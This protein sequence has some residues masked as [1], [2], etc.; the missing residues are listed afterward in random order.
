MTPGGTTLGSHHHHRAPRGLR[1]FQGQ[2]LK[3]EAN[4]T[5]QMQGFDIEAI[6][7]EVLENKSIDF[8][9]GAQPNGARLSCGASF[10]SSQTDGLLSKT[11]PSA[12]GA[13]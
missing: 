1:D 2:E 8:S 9:I 11:A 7:A 4:S 12:S 13:C 3:S 10:Q 5:G 6:C